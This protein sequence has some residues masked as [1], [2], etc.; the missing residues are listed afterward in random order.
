ME[1]LSDLFFKLEEL[2]EHV[3]KHMQFL[4]AELE[5]LCWRCVPRETHRYYSLVFQV[6]VHDAYTC[7]DPLGSLGVVLLRKGIS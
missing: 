7:W 3:L 6:I 1:A 4:W 2:T 5:C